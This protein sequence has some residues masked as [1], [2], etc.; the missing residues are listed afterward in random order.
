MDMDY[1]EKLKNLITILNKIESAVVAYSGGVD[2]TFLLKAASLSGIRTI[3]VTGFSPTMPKDDLEEAKKMAEVIGV[4]HMIIGTSEL[5]ID[6]FRKNSSDRCFHCKNELFGRL[7]DVAELEGYRF[8][9]DGSNLDDLDDWRPGRNAAIK[10]G[11]R[12]PLMEAG[13]GKKDIRGLSL[14]LNLST[15]D[16]PSSPCLS[17]RFPYGEPITVEALELVE[18][19]EKFL[20]SFGFREFRVRHLGDTARIEVKEEDIPRI[21]IPQIRIP[22]TEKL[23]ALGYKF[24]T[25]DLEGFRSGKLNEVLSK[26]ELP[27]H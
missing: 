14:E 26:S 24:I 2:S 15:W 19:A 1:T 11:I 16:K 12:S 5:G 25:L 18:S 21:L 22:V 10:H 23:R 13:L 7:K 20:R 3:A 17:S 27:Q 6:D 8:V 4:P 9:L